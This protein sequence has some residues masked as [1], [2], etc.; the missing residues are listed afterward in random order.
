MY[1]RGMRVY[2]ICFV[3]FF[4]GEVLLSSVDRRTEEVRQIDEEIEELEEKK[5]GLEAR[6]LRDENRGEFLQF[7]EE[8]VLETRKSF[9]RAEE[10]RL[11][12]R[13][14]QEE[15]DRLEKKKAELSKKKRLFG[16]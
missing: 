16:S 1:R 13:Q 7:K 11:K 8:F 3:L 15:I 4:S 9:K 5:R 6:A 2:A 14:V 12:A 10:Y